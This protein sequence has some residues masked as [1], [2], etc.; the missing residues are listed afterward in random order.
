MRLLDKDKKDNKED[1]WCH[2]S[3]LPS[4]KDY[5]EE[6]EWESNSTWSS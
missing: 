1:N 5:E 2:Y 4:P 3:G 6:E